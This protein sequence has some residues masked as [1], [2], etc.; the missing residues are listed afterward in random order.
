MTSRSS[1]LLALLLAAA[2]ALADEWYIENDV[3]GR[4]VITEDACPND[5]GKYWAFA[6]AARGDRLEGCWT[7]R[8]K[9]AF[10]TWENGTRSAYPLDKFEMNVQSKRKLG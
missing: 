4:I 5:T 3:G 2:P 9:M 8:Q 7:S 1:I 6:Y 10:V